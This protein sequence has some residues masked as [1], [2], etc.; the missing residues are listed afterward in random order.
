MDD[1][2]GKEDM[3]KKYLLAVILV[4]YSNVLYANPELN[5]G[6]EASVEETTGFVSGA[7]LGGLAGGPAGVILGASFGALLGNQWTSNKEAFEGMRVALEKSNLE[8]TSTRSQLASLNQGYN[9]V[10]SEL[11]RTRFPYSDNS[12]SI[13][14]SDAD[15]S[16]CEA[17]ISIHFKTGETEI[18]EHYKE[19]L[20]MI[21]SQARRIKNSKI[22]IFG[23]ADRNGDAENNL[24]LSKQRSNSV[25]NFLIQNGIDRTSVNTFAY[26]DTKPLQ[27]NSNYESDFFD[28]R[29]TIHMRTDG[30]R[31]FVTNQL[32]KDTK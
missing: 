25:E 26:G 28:R 6:S 8:L 19:E 2:G 14:N 10:T 30:V 4:F 20:K 3:F 15:A 31:S 9:S 22:E 32:V 7:I 21:A 23:Y 13:A 18:E 5:N 12:T 24:E 27:S 11:Q 29:V 16:C 17:K 1:P